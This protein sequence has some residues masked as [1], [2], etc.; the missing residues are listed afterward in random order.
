MAI[1]LPPHHQI[2]G[3]YSDSDAM[4]AGLSEYYKNMRDE[5]SFENEIPHSPERLEQL[6]RMHEA[7][8]AWGKD[9]GYDLSERLPRPEHYHYFRTSEDL[10][11]AIRSLGIEPHEDQLGGS[12]TAGILLL[13]SHDPDHDPMLVARHET[14][15]FIAG[16]KHKLVSREGGGYDISGAG[17]LIQ[18]VNEMFTDIIAMDIAIR[19]E[20]TQNTT[21]LYAS[22]DFIGDELIKKIARELDEPPLKILQEIER[23]YITAD[24]S[25]LLKFARVLPV[26]GR[27]A[28]VRAT[29]LRDTAS[30]VDLANKL[31]IPEAGEKIIAVRNG[32]ADVKL[33]EWLD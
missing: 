31:T 18:A 4:Q 2:T 26:E 1:D 5:R 15:H 30:Y 11:M 3:N 32:G 23:I 6:I 24:T 27:Q 29:H 7:M 19:Y 14:V 21:A 16:E 8:S 12:T 13:D 22:L 17:P 10:K 20:D 33:L 9:L 25:A 28:L